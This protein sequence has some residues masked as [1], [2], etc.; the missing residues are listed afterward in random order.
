MKHF[1][2][3]S[4]HHCALLLLVA[5]SIASAQIQESPLDTQ[6]LP[7]GQMF[8]LIIKGDGESDPPAR[9]TAQGLP[10]ESVFLRNLDGSRTF[11][12]IPDENDIGTSSF[13]VTI[14]DGSDEQIFATYP[15]N[16]EV[17]NIGSGEADPG[18]QLTEQ[19]TTETVPADTTADLAAESSTDTTTATENAA[20]PE[21]L[22]KA[23]AAKADNTLADNTSAVDG[24]SDDSVST[25]TV[26]ADTVTE[27]SVSTVPDSTDSDSS[28]AE[29]PDADAD[30]PAT[31]ATA[32]SQAAVNT[33]A[34]N[35]V[36]AITTVNDSTARPSAAASQ[37]PTATVVDVDARQD[38][39]TES[40]GPTTTAENTAINQPSPLPAVDIPDDGDNDASTDSELTIASKP[41]LEVPDD[42]TIA[43]NN[44]LSVPIRHSSAS[45]N[46]T[47][48]SA[49]N[50]PQ[51]ARLSETPSG[52]VLV[53]TPQPSDAGS[54]AIILTVTDAED[55]SLFTT[56][57]L[58]IVVTR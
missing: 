35:A 22:S 16:L 3:K 51:G 8:S 42:V 47:R 28:D 41:V 57:R 45:G 32:V 1:F 11:M 55:A 17:I 44:E 30:F 12:W 48:L 49:V 24:E 18:Q 26:N 37:L 2:F 38:S 14:A 52:H 58:G 53:W 5:S 7:T 21:P 46:N 56:R 43:A 15:I 19:P 29:T 40:S 4:L 31:N 34:T 54:T 9:I 33:V 27:E 20:A 10:P 6:I 50:L 13:L 39:T 25:D 36:D 23:A